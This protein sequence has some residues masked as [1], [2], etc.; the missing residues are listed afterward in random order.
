MTAND[1]IVFLRPSEIMSAKPREL[2]SEIF[3]LQKLCRDKDVA[4]EKAVK[5]IVKNICSCRSCDYCPVLPSVID[6][7]NQTTRMGSKL[8]RKWLY[9]SRSRI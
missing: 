6:E 7:C 3:R 2:R 8:I 9:K 5:I 4:I 1:P